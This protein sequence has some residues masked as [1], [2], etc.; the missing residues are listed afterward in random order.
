[1]SELIKNDML[2]EQLR[3]RGQMWEV[4]FEGVRVFGIDISINRE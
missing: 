4:W 2:L 1:M 3:L